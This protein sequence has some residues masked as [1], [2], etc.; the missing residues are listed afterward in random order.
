MK[1]E[2]LALDAAAAGER[3]G[4]MPLMLDVMDFR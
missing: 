4:T 1:G 3:A 2:T